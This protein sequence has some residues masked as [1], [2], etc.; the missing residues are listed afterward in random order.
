MTQ[1]GGLVILYAWLIFAGLLTVLAYLLLRHEQDPL[2]DLT[3]PG[4]D[5]QAE[6]LPG[7]EPS[8]SRKPNRRRSACSV[9]PMLQSRPLPWS[10][11]GRGAGCRGES[12]LGWPESMASGG[13][14]A[15]LLAGPTQACRCSG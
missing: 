11:T 1:T 8:P 2:Q 15:C 7:H 3:H 14:D 12:G 9:A 10:R 6:H 13:R 4:Q 5:D